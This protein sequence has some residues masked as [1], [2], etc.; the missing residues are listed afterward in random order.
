MALS[1]LQQ[2]SRHGQLM[3][4]FRDKILRARSCILSYIGN[5]FTRLLL[6][7]RL[8]A[9]VEN[10]RSVLRARFG[11]GKLDAVEF[12]DS[13]RLKL[14]DLRP[15]LEVLRDVYLE[16]VY[17]RPFRLDDHGVVL[18]LGA[19]IGVF[20]MIAATSLVPH[21]RV[22]AVEPNPAV[23]SVLEENVLA[24]CF[25]N[26]RVISGAVAVEPG[27][28]AL[29]LAQHS[30][31][32]TTAGS[33]RGVSVTVPAVSFSEL[34]TM[35]GRIE[36]VKC[37][38]EGAEWR[39]IYESDERIWSRIKRVAMEFHIDSGDGRT[40]ED[41][42]LRFKKLG[43]ENVTAFPPTCRSPLCGYIWASRA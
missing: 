13:T 6:L 42:I 19:N 25:R 2:E 26:I 21:G 37:D 27:T 40:H 9:K 10:W 32:S 39:I 16:R 3:R 20:S 8:I 15:G 18:D 30:L 34:V 29:R 28:I 43:Y 17:D 24:N 36:L 7:P 5:A 11:L 38:I 35:A 12:R 1:P 14:V 31:R 4:E 23:L 41:L 22:I 33:G